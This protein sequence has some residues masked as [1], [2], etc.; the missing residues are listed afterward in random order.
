MKPKYDSA[1]IGYKVYRMFTDGF[2]FPLHIIRNG[3]SFV[4]Q[5]LSG[6]DYHAAVLMGHGIDDTLSYFITSPLAAR[7]NNELYKEG[8]K[9]DWIFGATRGDLTDILD[10]DEFQTIVTAGHG[11]RST[12]VANDAEVTQKQ[13]SAF[14]GDRPKKTGYWFQHSCG[15]MHGNPLGIDV[16]Y[17]PDERCLF[18]LNGVNSYD[19]S[20]IGLPKNSL[21]SLQE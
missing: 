7:I 4:K 2:L 15:S 17:K 6:R 19:M 10:K 20:W 12:W 5:K 8:V 11:D 14:Y 13:I 18:F 21:K 3:S 9:T 16:M 1:P